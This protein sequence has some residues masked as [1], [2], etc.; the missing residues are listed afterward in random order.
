[1][2]RTSIDLGDEACARVMERFQLDSK[3]EAVNFALQRLAPDS[4]GL[5]EALELEGSGWGGDL[6]EMRG[7]RKR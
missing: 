1:M 7:S 2:A 5:R 4:L 6:E 3:Q